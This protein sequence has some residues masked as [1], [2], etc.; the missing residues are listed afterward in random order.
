[1]VRRYPTAALPRS[2]RR[3]GGGPIL[4]GLVYVLAIVGMIVAAAQAD[5]ELAGDGRGTGGGG[6]GGMA[7]VRSA[8]YHFHPCL[9]QQPLHSGSCSRR[10]WPWSLQK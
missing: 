4:V 3:F 5:F 8:S 9:R 1:M 6:G 10:P 2:D 7:A